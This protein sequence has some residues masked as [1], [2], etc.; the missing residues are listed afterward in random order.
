M[1]KFDG[2]KVFSAS[3][4]APRQVLGETVTR[5]LE[6]ARRRPGFEVVDIVVRQS[7]DDAFHLVSCVIFYKEPIKKAAR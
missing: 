4:F 7:S 6:E 3:M 5:W 2:V 1:N